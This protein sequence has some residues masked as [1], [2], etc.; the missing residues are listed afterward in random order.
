MTVPFKAS[1]REEFVRVKLSADGLVALSNQ[2]SGVL[3]SLQQ[4]DGLIR[5]PVGESLNAGETA[6]FWFMHEL[7]AP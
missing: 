2:S 6:E 4:A 3:S 1:E 7:I 5:L